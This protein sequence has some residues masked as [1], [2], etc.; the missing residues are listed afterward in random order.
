M[1]FSANTVL[2]LFIVMFAGFAARKAGLI[3]GRA[4]SAINTLVFYMCVSCMMFQNTA[5]IRFTDFFD[6]GFILYAMLTTLGVFLAAL[7]Y[8]ALFIKE[9]PS[10]GSFIQGSFRG[11]FAYIGVPLITAMMGDSRSVKMAV[12]VAFVVPLY[13][14]LSITILTLKSDKIADKR[15]SGV[16]VRTVL[17]NIVKNPLIIGI[18]LGLAFSLLNLSLPGALDKSVTYLSQMAAPA[19]LLCVG[20]NIDLKSIKNRINYLIPAALL[21]CVI[22]PAV[23]IPLA[24]LLGMNREAIIVLFVLYSTPTAAASYVMAD[25]MGC[26]GTLAAN[27]IAVTTLL[28]LF[29]FT[30]GIFLLRTF[31]II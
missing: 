12:V 2:P 24:L 19:A 4:V 6:I 27:I 23:F 17:L 13:N 31:G 21:K 20:A 30:G 8:S 10:V 16:F 5:G 14:V 26:D 3:D 15:F 28:S 11:N 1:I 18:A 22:P 9:S 25:A 29:T 7:A